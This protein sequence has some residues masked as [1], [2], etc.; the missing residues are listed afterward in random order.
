MAQSQQA[1]YVPPQSHWPIIGAV[2]LFCT[3]GG[4][5]ILL[6]ALQQ[7]GS[8][9]LGRIVILSGVLILIGMM[10]GWFASVIAET[11]QGLYSPQLD[12]SFRYGMSWFIFSEVMFFFAFFG[13]LFYIRV[14]AV[15]WLGGEGDKGLANMLWPQFDAIWPLMQ[16]PNTE[17]FTPIKEIINPW[18]VPFINTIL[19]VTSSFTLLASHKALKR[20]DRSKVKTWLALTIVLGLSFLGLQIMEYSKAYTEM[21]LTLSSG[22]YGATFFILT[23]FHGAHVTVGSIILIVLL[24]RVLKGHFSPQKH[25]A[26]EAG[27]WYWHFVDVVWLFLFTTVYLL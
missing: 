11:H 3:L 24:L 18:H 12:K 20:N 19:L 2:G 8:G 26:F 23:G 6:H 5:G 4:T 21:D 1:Y 13:T 25:F 22:I 17:Q 15:P 27:S 14:F 9:L 7:G 10:I 16:A